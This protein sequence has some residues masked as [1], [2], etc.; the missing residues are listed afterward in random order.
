MLSTLKF[1]QQRQFVPEPSATEAEVA[2]GKLNSYTLPGLEQIP[3][4]LL[5]GGGGETLHCV[6]QKLIKLI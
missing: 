4:D 1:I 6:I 3:P 2:I 5:Q